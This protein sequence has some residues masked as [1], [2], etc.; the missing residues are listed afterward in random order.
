MCVIVAT[1][2]LT[3]LQRPTVTMGARGAIL[4]VEHGASGA[5]HGAY[6]A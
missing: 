1:L 4:H 2:A 6:P 5:N 3:R